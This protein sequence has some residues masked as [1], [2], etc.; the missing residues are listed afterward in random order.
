[1]APSW[2]FTENL[3]DG[4]KILNAYL[5]HIKNTYGLLVIGVFL[6]LMLFYSSAALADNAIAATDY[7][8][9]ET[10]DQN[11]FNLIHGQ[12][13]PTNATLIAKQQDLWSI[14]LVITNT[15]NTESKKDET[16]YLDYEAYRFNLSYQYGLNKNWNVKID[17]PV[18]HQSGGIFDSPI[19]S[20]HKL[21]GLP[22]G[23]RS[24]IKDNQYNVIY[25]SQSQTR[26]DLDKSSTTLGDIQLAAAR[27][28]LNNEQTSLSLWAGL[29]L[30]T[31]NKNKLSGSGAADVSSWLA[32]NQ[33]LTQ[34]WL[35]NINTGIVIPGSNKYKNMPIANSVAYG[36]L[37]LGWLASDSIS[38]KLQLQGHT[39]YYKKSDLKILGDTYMLTFGTSIKLNQCNQLD[40][41][42]SEDIK[43]NA[44][45]DVSLLI[46]WRSYSGR[47]KSSL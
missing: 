5:S 26:I 40:I 46:N 12:A 27:T 11:L 18:M 22:K 29:K 35:I 20:F 21:M 17:V 25:N 41:A 8:P 9:F 2:L 23:Q 42:M 34:S 24:S 31:G 45:P 32:L 19:D 6:C 15:V 43:V 44:T 28:L 30:P 10:R 33:Q 36:H 39:S 1:M 47:C 38:L 13:L 7:N 16:I 3:S 37:M 14:G 4:H